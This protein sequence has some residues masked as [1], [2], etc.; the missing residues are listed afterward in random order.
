MLWL[1]VFCFPFTAFVAVRTS[2]FLISRCRRIETQ[3]AAATP[4]NY[5]LHHAF[6][7]SHC[8]SVGLEKDNVRNAEV[9]LPKIGR[10]ETRKWALLFTRI[11]CRPA[12]VV[13]AL[14]FVAVRLLQND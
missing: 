9:R 10:K 3:C 11:F 2:A 5:I 1:F 14:L 7:K 6:F 4:A 8:V 13:V 12:S